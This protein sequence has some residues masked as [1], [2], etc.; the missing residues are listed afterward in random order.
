M[1]SRNLGPALDQRHQRANYSRPLSDFGILLRQKNAVL[2][3]FLS[4]SATVPSQICITRAAFPL[5]GPFK[6]AR[7]TRYV[8]A[9]LASLGMFCLLVVLDW[10]AA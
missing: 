7:M 8:I 9:F 5:H 3:V 6:I 4:H 2:V 10:L 1:V